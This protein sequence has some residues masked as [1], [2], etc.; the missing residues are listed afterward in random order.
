MSTNPP[1]SRTITTECHV[2]VTADIAGISDKLVAAAKYGFASIDRQTGQIEWL[3]RVYEGEGPDVERRMRMNDGAV[4][5]YG[6]FWVGS[7]ND[8]HLVDHWPKYEGS[9]FRLDPDGSVHTIL[10]HALAVPNG[11]AWN[12]AG[13]IM[14][15]TESDTKDIYAFDFDAE[16][17]RISNKRIFFHNQTEGLP[18]G[19]VVDEEDCLWSALW[20]GS[21][22]IRISPSGDIIGVIDLPCPLVTCPTFVDTDLIITTANYAEESPT[23]HGGGVFRVNVGVRRG[24]NHKA[25]LQM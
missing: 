17:G 6:R 25:K 16:K 4:D 13:D 19:L 1:S 11:I 3:Q 14:Y 21:Q 22:V 5:S 7:M 24:R 2:G 18:D 12:L 20:R 10:H 8:T 9:L 23:Q 15:L